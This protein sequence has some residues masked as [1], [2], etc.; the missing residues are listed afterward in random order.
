MRAK[1]RGA[2]GEGRNLFPDPNKF[3]N[4]SASHVQVKRFA[5]LVGDKMVYDQI[6]IIKEWNNIFKVNLFSSLL[7]V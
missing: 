7:N 1:V 4:S 5:K 6:Y 3:F 2:G